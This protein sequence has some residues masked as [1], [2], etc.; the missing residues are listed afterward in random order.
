MLFVL[1]Y[2][3]RLY[4]KKFE[5]SRQLK[6]EAASDLA[7]QEY[8]ESCDLSSPSKAG[9]ADAAQVQ[10]SS[11]GKRAASGGGGGSSKGKK[12]RSSR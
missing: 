6:A 1:Q 5:M 10:E 7:V 2:L 8:M 11:R 12:S 4:A 3:V 9:P